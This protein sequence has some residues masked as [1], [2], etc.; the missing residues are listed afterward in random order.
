MTTTTHHHHPPHEARGGILAS[1][2]RAAH[3]HCPC[4][5]QTFVAATLVVTSRMARTAAACDHPFAHGGD[6]CPAMRSRPCAQNPK[7]L[8]KGVARLSHR[9]DCGVRCHARRAY[10]LGARLR[11]AS[12]QTTELSNDIAGASFI[13]T[14]GPYDSPRGAL[15]WRMVRTCSSRSLHS[16]T[17]GAEKSWLMDYIVI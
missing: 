1:H 11:A 16:Q 5:L 14:V 7:D 9:L 13:Y 3:I 2:P 8:S 15:Q 12:S 10:F 4:A 17:L 6:S